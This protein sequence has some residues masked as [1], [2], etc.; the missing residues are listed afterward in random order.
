MEY[1]EGHT[2]QSGSQMGDYRQGALSLGKQ[3]ADALEA[4]HRKGIVH[5]DLKPA[6][7]MLTTSGVKVLDFGLARMK[8]K[9]H[10]SSENV[11]VAMTY[12]GTILG[13]FQYMSPEQLEAK[14]ADARSVYLRL[15]RGAVRDADGAQGV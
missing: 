10:P 14:D 2:L 7:V 1:L 8:S 15:R 11:T 5:R 4:A 13:T 3:I 12:P 9:E 6:N